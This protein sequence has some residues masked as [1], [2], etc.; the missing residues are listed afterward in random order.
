VETEGITITDIS[1]YLHIV[2]ISKRDY[3]TK[4]RKSR[5]KFSE[6]RTIVME[7]VQAYL[8]LSY[9]ELA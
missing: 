4:T 3:H 1:Y 6:L 9:Q 5:A 2:C 7:T 8:S